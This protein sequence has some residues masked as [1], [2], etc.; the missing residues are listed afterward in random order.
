MIRNAHISFNYAWIWS[1]IMSSIGQYKSAGG[2]TVHE[3]ASEQEDRIVEVLSLKSSLKIHTLTLVKKKPL[4]A[5]WTPHVST[6]YKCRLKMQYLSCMTQV[7]LLVHQ[8]QFQM[9][10]P[11]ATYDWWSGVF[12]EMC[13]CIAPG[14]G[15]GLKSSCKVIEVC[16]LMSH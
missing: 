5:L 3:W 8:I 2:R 6:M 7:L 13:L 10:L 4:D 14:R 11:K 1:K 16:L 9:S 15:L 12:R